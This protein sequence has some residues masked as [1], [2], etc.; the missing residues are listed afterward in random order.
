MNNIREK[1]REEKKNL[2]LKRMSNEHAE[3][4]NWDCG[5]GMFT[6]TVI[7]L[8]KRWLLNSLADNS[9]MPLRTFFSN[10][11]HNKKFYCYF[12]VSWNF[13]WCAQTRVFHAELIVGILATHF[14][15]QSNVRVT[16]LLSTSSD[17]IRSIKSFGKNDLNHLPK[18]KRKKKRERKLMLL[19]Q[20]ITRR[21]NLKCPKIICIYQ[22][23]GAYNLKWD[24]YTINRKFVVARFNRL[25]NWLAEQFAFIVLDSDS[26]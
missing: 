11:A 22:L 8:H 18:M 25:F 16:L 17:G 10:S 20:R 12:W 5:L 23:I 7:F 14:Y 19:V 24:F 15:L 6:A 9:W 21:F 1:R 26:L 3:R 13:E 2:L 4:V